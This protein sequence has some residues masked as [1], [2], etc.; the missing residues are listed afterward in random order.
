MTEMRGRVLRRVMKQT[1]AD[2]ILYGFLGVWALCALAIWIREP[3]I[4]SYGDALWY[5]YAVVTTIGF[6]DVIVYTAFSKV[7]SVILSAYAAVVIAMIT[8]VI[9]NFYNEMAAVRRNETLAAFADRLE[10]L[11]E[12]SK[13]E[14]QELS[15]EV[16]HFRAGRKKN[17][18]RTGEN[19]ST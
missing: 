12:L 18:T 17:G 15:E 6:G 14:L 5:C 10:R 9:V 13:E 7:I 2:K 16:K 3:E 4:K 8:G 1:G 11:P 19:I